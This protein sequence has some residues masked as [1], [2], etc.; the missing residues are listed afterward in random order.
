MSIRYAP[1]SRVDET[2]KRA[3]AWI[4]R[5]YPPGWC[6][7]WVATEVYAVPGLGDYDGDGSADAEDYWKAAV[8][9]GTAVKISDPAKIPAG[10]MIMWT[11]GSGDHGHAAYSLGGGMMV[12]TDLPTR[13]KVGRVKVDDVRRLWGLKLV[14]YIT[15]SGN[16]WTLIRDPKDV[17]QVTTKAGLNVREEPDEKSP[18]LRV[19]EHGERVHVVETRKV[20]SRTWGRIVGGGWIATSYTKKVS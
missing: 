12:S 9:K 15:K 14:G 6:L 16:G 17:R 20:G 1:H 4:G 11:G 5:K 7:R 19:L 10:V 18:R 3:L 13:G 2:T 8:A